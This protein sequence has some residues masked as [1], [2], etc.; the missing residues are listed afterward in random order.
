MFS[1]YSVILDLIKA[2]TH[3]YVRR[4]P[5]GATTTGATKYRYFYHGQEGHGKGLAH[6]SELLVG[7]SFVFNAEGQNKY[8]A[9]IIK[10]DGDMIT[11]KHDDG[12]KKGT[13]HIYTKEAFQKLVHFEHRKAL[14]QARQKASKQLSEFQQMKERGAK[15]K[16]ETLNKLEQRVKTLEAPITKRE[17]DAKE[18]FSS[19]EKGKLKTYT[20][21]QDANDALSKLATTLDTKDKTLSFLQ[22]YKDHSQDILD[23]LDKSVTNQDLYKEYGMLA[24]LLNSRND[25]ILSLAKR[26]FQGIRSDIPLI[27]KDNLQ[28]SGIRK[29]FKDW[30][31]HTISSIK[32]TQ[33]EITQRDIDKAKSAYTRTKKQEQTEQAS[34][35]KISEDMQQFIKNPRS[36]RIGTSTTAELIQ[37]IPSVIYRKNADE[38]IA[39]YLATSNGVK[40]ANIPNISDI[41]KDQINRRVDKEPIITPLNID[42][43]REHLKRFPEDKEITFENM[44][45]LQDTESLD[46][47]F[48]SDGLN[49]LRNNLD[50]TLQDSVKQE[51]TNKI[52]QNTQA[53]NN[54]QNKQ[55]IKKILGAITGADKKMTSEKLNDG[56]SNITG[57]MKTQK[58]ILETLQQIK[59]NA[60]SL[61]A[62]YKQ[63]YPNKND[64]SSAY[65]KEPF[66]YPG[67]YDLRSKESLL[68]EL[69][70]AQIFK[71]VIYNTDWADESDF[72][73]IDQDID[74]FWGHEINYAKDHTLEEALDNLIQ[75]VK[76]HK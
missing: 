48:D 30:I 25:L 74:N 12:A 73:Q 67:R 32:D 17:G 14:E 15:V 75:H 31:D 44:P 20:E 21:V 7:A 42:A 43:V 55:Q 61:L 59:T 66:S 72:H 8:H 47:L 27:Q 49:K 33:T 63:A 28:I 41:L 13:E 37:Q 56:L 22:M 10:V 39:F 46:K 65:I 76:R 26:N 5:V 2:R 16:Q 54:T 40:F 51:N 18:I 3:K 71:N 4:I 70:T 62:S 57:L 11:V 53:Q 58:D 1:F 35:F 60:Q 50:G 24:T 9:H 34:P 45:I 52:P 38:V 19:F 68:K 64:V 69:I 23:T 6:E 36:I 29:G